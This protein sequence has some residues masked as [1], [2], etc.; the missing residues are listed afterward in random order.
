VRIEAARGLAARRDAGVLELIR[1]ELASV[2]GAW[3]VVDS[4]LR[5]CESGRQEDWAG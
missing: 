2:D 3:Q 4:A 5:A 1:D